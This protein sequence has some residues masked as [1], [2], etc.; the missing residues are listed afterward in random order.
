[1]K[2]TLFI[3]LSL[4]LLLPEIGF[5]KEIV[6]VMDAEHPHYQ[7]ALQGFI[8]ACG[9]P[10]APVQGVKSIRTVTPH[11]VIIGNK[12]TEEATAHVRDFRPD[13]ILAIGNKGL[14]TAVQI[15]D[16]PII[17]LLVANPTR[18]IGKRKNITGIELNLPA[19]IQLKAMREH[20]PN[21]K[22][23]GVI[24]DQQ[25]TGEF[26]SKAEHVAPDHA[27]NLVEMPLTQRSGFP[28]LLKSLKKADIDAYWM[29]P[30]LSVL[31]PTNLHDLLL[32]SLENKIPII[33]FTDKYLQHGAAMS[34]TFD[35]WAIGIQA[36][37]I[38]HSIMTGTP[39]TDLPPQS[40]NKTTVKV[41]EK[42]IKKLGVPFKVAAEKGGS[43]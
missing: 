26:V 32:F 27:I 36:G 39:V 12:S 6:V 38:A 33:T 30:D 11:K 17:Y 21:M 13:V 29:I 5:G 15:Q 19:N 20:L 22:R 35:T 34:I 14:Q 18:I 8:K 1:M 7:K 24:Y 40:A 2:R 41:N 43:Q 31:N 3:F 23:L 4:L 28:K 25:R 10:P 42:I 9:C 16:V 37:K